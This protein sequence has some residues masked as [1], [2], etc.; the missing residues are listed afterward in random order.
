MRLIAEKA[1]LI[2]PVEIQVYTVKRH[3]SA[4]FVEPMDEYSMQKAANLINDIV[5]KRCAK[6][7][8]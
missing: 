6:I 4:S 1:R 3:P 8:L 7:Y 2:N 5:G